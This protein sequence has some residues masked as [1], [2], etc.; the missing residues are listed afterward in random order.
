MEGNTTVGKKDKEPFFASF[1]KSQTSSVISTALDFVTSGV[2]YYGLSFNPLIASPIGNICGAILSFY[3]GRN[4]AFKKQDG[5]IS[6]QAVRYAI[7]SFLSAAINTAGIAFLVKNYGM[8]AAASKTVVA[9]VV[10][11]TFNFMMFR[12]FVYK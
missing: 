1:V 4:W 9:I 7:A 8:D 2:L 11:A 6:H 5:K 3:L 10:G 12:Y